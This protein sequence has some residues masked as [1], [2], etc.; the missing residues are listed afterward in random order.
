M[1]KK[2][3]TLIELLV[4]IVIMGVVGTSSMIMFNNIDDDT[5]EVDREN[6][7]KTIQRSAILYLDLNDDWLQ[8]FKDKKEMFIEM[9]ELMGTNYVS[10]SLEDPVTNEEIP[11]NYIVKLYISKD[12]HGR[13]Y[14]D[15]CILD[16]DKLKSS[17][18]ESAC[19]VD[20]EGKSGKY[21]CAACVPKAE[22]TA[23]IDGTVSSSQ[24]IIENASE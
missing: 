14:M 10:S 11:S 19:V 16:K 12:R 21:C 13:E 20:S 9:S 15:S 5:A 4:V 8:Q 3:F 7:Y 18:E 2:G 23:N 22:A 17:K 1:N 6:T 24:C